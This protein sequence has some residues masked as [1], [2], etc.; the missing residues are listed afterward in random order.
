MSKQDDKIV[1]DVEND[2][3]SVLPGAEGQVTEETEL[4]TVKQEFK[5]LQEQFESL[6]SQLKR[7]LADYQNLEKRV[8]DGRSQL[9]SFVGAGIITNL[10]PVINHFDQAVMGA[11]EDEKKSGWFKGV[12]M[13]LKQL[14]A[15]LKQEGLEEIEAKDEFDPSLHEAVDTTEG[16][17]GK[18]IK[19]TE[20]GYRLN[21]KVIKP[22]KV[23]VGK[24]EQK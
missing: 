14:K 19:V 15:V 8:A 4:E 16:E 24:K 18:I 10:L 9:S 22:V 7:A 20:L 2:L 11:G 6:N 3:D 17:D 12:E 23:V 5:A 13:A 1:Q 21:G